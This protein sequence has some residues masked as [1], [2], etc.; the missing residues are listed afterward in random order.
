MAQP[1]SWRLMGAL[2]LLF[3][4]MGGV[5]L[6]L[7]GNARA[8][9][10]VRHLEIALPF[11]KD[12]HRQPITLAL[13]TDTHVGPENS[14]ERMARIVDQV[15]ALKPDLVVLGGDYIGDAKGGGAYGPAASIAPFA[16]LRARLGVVAVLGN[17]DSPS[18]SR[19]DRRQWHDLFAG[20]GIRL[21]DNQAVRRGPL[22]LGGLRDIYT[23]RPDI[24]GTLEQMQALGGVRVVLSHGPDVF[25]Q[26]PD[27]PM[28]ALV[29]H[30]HCGQVAF[31]F[32]GIVNVP[33]RYGT[34]YACGIYREGARTMVVS[35][36]VGTSRLPIRMLAAPDL[37]LITIHPQ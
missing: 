2:L 10:V 17:H 15:N 31:P 21:L 22:A 28:L 23:G 29:G 24:P 8:M 7:V 5:I 11:P 34:R 3:A 26:L 4:M 37:W 16:R 1:F 27:Q 33:S 13:M 36:G 20:I 35:G 12:A 19:I 25:P 6:R 18:H 9:P 32:L 14:P 30:T